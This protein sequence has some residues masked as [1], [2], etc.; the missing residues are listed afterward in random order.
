LSTK[1]KTLQKLTTIKSRGSEWDGASL[2]LCLPFKI[3]FMSLLIKKW[4]PLIVWLLL[5]AWIFQACK[6]VPITGRKKLSLMPE[7]QVRTMS[8][9]Q[10][11][12]VLEEAELSKDPDQVQL[13][14]RVGERIQAAVEKYMS[15]T[16][17]A[18]VLE[19]FE[20]EFNLIESDQVNAWCMPGGKVAFYTGIL[21]ICADEKG[22]AV[23][24]GHEVAHAIAGHGSERMSQQVLA[25]LGQQVITAA[26][27]EESDELRSIYLTAFGAAAQLG[28]LLPFSRKHESEADQMG[29]I[30]MALA[31]YDPREAPEFWR[32]MAAQGG[33]KPPEFMSTH[34]SDQR[35]ISDLE[36]QMAS[37]LGY[38][39]P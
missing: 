22:I 30:F 11:A 32:R 8:F 18:E 12:H 23:V 14:R 38:Y 33:E 6:T 16:G 17:H 13:V 5:G 3:R 21:P 37:A 29:L 39:T 36:A 24:M 15:S 35:R 10:Y 25:Q 31:G 27:V 1:G 4:T 34:P 2:S 20:W 7:S 19:G 9:Q 26:T 28:V